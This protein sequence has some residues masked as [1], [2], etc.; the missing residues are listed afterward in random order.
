VT[1]DVPPSSGHDEIRA[2]LGAYALDAVD[3]PERDRIDG[4]LAGCPGCREELDALLDVAGRLGD[5][6]GASAPPHVWEGIAASLAGTGAGEDPPGWVTIAGRLTRPDTGAAAVEAR[7]APPPAPGPAPGRRWPLRA[8]LALAAALMLVVA[9][10]SLHAA[11]LQHRVTALGSGNGLTRAEQA[12]QDAPGTR[13]VVLTAS[14]VA[15]SPGPRVTVVLPRRGPGFVEAGTLGPLPG[16]RTYQLWGITDGAAV[17][18]GVLGPHPGVAAVAVGGPAPSELAITEEA[19]G[20]AP[21]PTS[22]PLVR[23]TVPA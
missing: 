9:G 10:L 3:G 21:Q 20:G 5:T 8:A 15:G 12:A 19:A 23:G 2:A 22:P 11:Q 16:D 6:A 17:S 13:R 14:T 7:P 1:G 4:H 18:L